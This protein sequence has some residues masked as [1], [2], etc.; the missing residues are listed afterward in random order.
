MKEIPVPNV[1]DVK[2]FDRFARL[3]ER[4]AFSISV[5]G[6][7]LPY[8]FYCLSVKSKVKSRTSKHC[9]NYFVS[10]AGVRRH[11][12]RHGCPELHGLSEDHNDTEGEVVEI[13]EEESSED[14]VNQDDGDDVTPVPRIP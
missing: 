1:S 8:D 6:S 11:L 14:E 7:K 9:Q 10:I 2:T 5:A 3:W 12:M 4:K 13:D